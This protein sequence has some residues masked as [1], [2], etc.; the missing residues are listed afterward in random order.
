[1]THATIPAGRPG[2]REHGERGRP[3]SGLSPGL[4]DVVRPPEVAAVVPMGTR[5]GV[6]PAVMRSARPYADAFSHVH[7]HRDKVPTAESEEP[8]A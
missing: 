1:M 7:E 6:P 2:N 3:A 4:W 8:F 5:E